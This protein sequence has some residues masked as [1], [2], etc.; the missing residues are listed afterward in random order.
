MTSAFIDYSKA[1]EEWCLA[2]FMAT[3]P[4]AGKEARAYLKERGYVNQVNRSAQQEKSP[5]ESTGLRF[6]F[7]AL[8]R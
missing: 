5:L 1:P 3:L 8:T 4:H 6:V 7:G 2:E